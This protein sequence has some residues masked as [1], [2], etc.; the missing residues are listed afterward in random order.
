MPTHRVFF[1]CACV[2]VSAHVQKSLWVLLQGLSLVPA[3]VVALSGWS[4][5]AGI[6]GL[7]G[8]CLT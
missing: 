1:T 5:A 7:G 3:T 8:F 6:D 4:E 2:R